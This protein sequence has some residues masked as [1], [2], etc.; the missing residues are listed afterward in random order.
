MKRL[1]D[2]NPDPANGQNQDISTAY[3]IEAIPAFTVPAVPGSKTASA[4]N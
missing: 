4:G 3:H 1:A 2:S